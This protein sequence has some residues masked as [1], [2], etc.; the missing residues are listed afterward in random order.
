MKVTFYGPRSSLPV[1]EKEMIHGFPFFKP[2]CDPRR[3]FT[4]SLC[5]KRFG[6]AFLAIEG[7]TIEF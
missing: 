3:H 1:P 4:L 7:Q 6:G 2:D 5:G